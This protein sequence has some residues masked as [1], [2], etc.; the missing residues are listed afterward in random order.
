M[1]TSEVSISINQFKKST[2]KYPFNVVNLITKMNKRSYV[3][4]EP[5]SQ[6]YI[7]VACFE[8]KEKHQL[9]LN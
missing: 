1:F 6:F 5:K 4:I 3:T 8:S 2:E 9:I 7:K